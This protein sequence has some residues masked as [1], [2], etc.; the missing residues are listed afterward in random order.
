VKW[1]ILIPAAFALTIIAGCETV[2]VESQGI[3]TGTPGFVTA[4]LPPSP[5]L[6]PTGTPP[7]PSPVPT[8]PPVEGRTTAQVNVRADTTTASAS[9][10]VIQ[11]FTQVQIIGRDASGN[12]Y[13]I[14]Y[15]DSEAGVGWVRAEFVQ[16]AAS[17][18]I[19]V[20]R[21]G[22][23]GGAEGSGVI[24]QRIN[25]RSG[26]GA[27]SESLGILNPKDVVSVLGR[28]A[29]GN[30]AQIKFAGAPD[31]MGWVAA[32]FIEVAGFDSLP[33][34]GAVE[35]PVGVEAVPSFVPSAVQDG[36]SLESPIVQAALEASG[37][38]ALLASGEVSAPEGD[39]E[40]WIGF[41]AGGNAVVIEIQ[42]SGNSL[43]MEL[44]NNGRALD[45]FACGER[46]AVNVAP[47]SAYHLRVFA[48]GAEEPHHT[49]YV[50]KIE[51]AW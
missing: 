38:R 47:G 20:V 11:Q 49:R 34:I 36:D 35:A 2:G 8:I 45:A 19:P 22:A 12:W 6:A 25:V 51:R 46:R 30:W 1:K 43:R 23:G 4:T 15:A 32:E 16:A 24:L 41:S 14:I 33:V 13:Q 9:L 48:P 44:W 27:G 5:T 7:P 3:P 18:E 29:G 37:A 40:D 10:G 28:D 42:C 31:G 50:V 21:T 39:N 17:A 26:P